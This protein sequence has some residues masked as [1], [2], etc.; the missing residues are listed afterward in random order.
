MK[1]E[2]RKRYRIEIEWDVGNPYSN[3]AWT[4]L[5]RFLLGRSVDYPIENPSKDEHALQMNRVWTNVGLYLIACQPVMFVVSWIVAEGEKP[6]S[7]SFG[8]LAYDFGVYVAI[9]VAA[10]WTVLVVPVAYLVDRVTRGRLSNDRRRLAIILACGV[11]GYLSTLIVAYI[12]AFHPIVLAFILGCAAY[13]AVFSMSGVGTPEQ[14]R[15]DIPSSNS[16]G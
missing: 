9:Y 7:L 16:I 6:I 11:T 1:P 4:C 5:T 14:A 15:S 10:F 12:L 2:R 3:P 8:R 13:G